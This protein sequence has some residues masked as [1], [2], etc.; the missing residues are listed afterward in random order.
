MSNNNGIVHGLVLRGYNGNDDTPSREPYE[1]RRRKGNH[2]GNAYKR[3][4]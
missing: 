3:K 1:Q 4:P 2:N